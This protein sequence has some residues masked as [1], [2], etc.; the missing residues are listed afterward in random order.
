MIQDAPANMQLLC[1]V[2]LKAKVR[3]ERR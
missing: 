1:D 2:A 3:S